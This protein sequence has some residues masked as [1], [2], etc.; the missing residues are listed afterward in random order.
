M[1]EV[2]E[3]TQAAPK[4]SASPSSV[5]ARAA[6]RAQRVS[7]K[8][9]TRTRSRPGLVLPKPKKV[10]RKKDPGTYLSMC[11]KDMALL[12]VLRPEEEFVAAREIEDLE[13]A[14]W[15]QLL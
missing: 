5:R 2:F 10:V 1:S 11:F 8:A 4:L 7:A 12:D 14:L 15:R 9:T 6:G 3:M 13:Q